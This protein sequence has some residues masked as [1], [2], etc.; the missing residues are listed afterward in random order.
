MRLAMPDCAGRVGTGGGFPA[1]VA[2]GTQHGGRPSE[3]PTGGL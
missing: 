2:P 3:P 1:P